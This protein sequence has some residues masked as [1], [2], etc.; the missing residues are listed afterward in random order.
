MFDRVGGVVGRIEIHM[1]CDFVAT[2]NM[3]VY[4]LTNQGKFQSSGHGRIR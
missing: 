4:A 2:E 1:H 3:L